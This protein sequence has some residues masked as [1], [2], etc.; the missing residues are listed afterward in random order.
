MLNE[1]KELEHYITNPQ[2]DEPRVLP[3]LLTNWYKGKLNGLQD[4]LV[5]IS[6][7]FIFH[8][9][10]DKKCGQE[11]IYDAC[12]AVLRLWCGFEDEA[13]NKQLQKNPYVKGWLKKYP[14]ANGW[15]K[16]YYEYHTKSKEKNTKTWEQYKAEW[17]NKLLNTYH[18]YSSKDFCYENM[19]AD[20][21]AMGELKEYY[22]AIKGNQD[23]FW[24]DIQKNN[25]TPEKRTR[26]KTLKL[27][28]AYLQLQKYYEHS[29]MVLL[30]KIRVLNWM[31]ISG[32][33]T[34][35][36][37][38]LIKW[39]NKYVF[40]S[41]NGYDYVKLGIDKEF[42][43]T[44]NIQLIDADEK[45]KFIHQGYMVFGDNGKELELINK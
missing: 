1:F 22:L 13:T 43:S 37:N 18:I 26:D 29:D 21:I 41:E 8:Y 17:K 12:I 38:P 33:N 31:G 42:L 24:K 35:D 16:E 39:S 10:L 32:R 9:M 40:K 28:A 20:A 3:T 14:E 23:M 25:K 4:I 34:E 15:L 2:S 6:R 7:G 44:Y 36:W 45:S 19:L 27:L 11:E 5:L 30:R